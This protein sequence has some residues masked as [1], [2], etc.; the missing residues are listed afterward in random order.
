M[1]IIEAEDYNQFGFKKYIGQ[2]SYGRIKKWLHII[3]LWDLAN[4]TEKNCSLDSMSF[5]C[6]YLLDQKLMQKRQKSNK[7]KLKPIKVLLLSEMTAD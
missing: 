2:K 5:S 4:S 3:S 7:K 6:S 1:E